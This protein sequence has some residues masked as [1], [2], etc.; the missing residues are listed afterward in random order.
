MLGKVTSTS[1]KWYSC[2]IGNYIAQ[3]KFSLSIFG[4]LLVLLSVAASIG[5]FGLIGIPSTI[6][7]FQVLPFLVLAVGVDNIFILVESYQN[8]IR[9]DNESPTTHLGRAVGE[10]IPSMFMSTAAQ[11]TGFFLGALSDMPAVKWFA[12]YAAVSLTLNFIMQITCFVAAMS[13]DEQRRLK[14]KKVDT[15]NTVS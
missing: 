14:P 3:K 8:S 7:S 6:V 5:L 13:I 1:K 12:L 11:A 15:T 10:V 4:V 9:Q 2:D